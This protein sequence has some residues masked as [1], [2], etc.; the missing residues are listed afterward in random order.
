MIRDSLDG[1]VFSYDRL[2]GNEVDRKHYE[3]DDRHELE[4]FREIHEVANAGEKVGRLGEWGCGRGEGRS[5]GWSRVLHH[6]I[7]G[8]LKWNLGNPIGSLHEHDFFVAGLLWGRM[9]LT[10]RCQLSSYIIQS[11]LD[12][13]IIV[14]DGTAASTR[15]WLRWLLQMVTHLQLKPEKS[16]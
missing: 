11:F 6:L 1:D 13:G 2:E 15:G 5:K 7:V 8:L 10:R 3:K 9:R 16:L 12:F 14:Y 4:V